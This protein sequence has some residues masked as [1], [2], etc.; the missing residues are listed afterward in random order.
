M[1]LNAYSVKALQRRGIDVAALGCVMLDVDGPPISRLLPATWLYWSEHPDRQWISGPQDS[2]HVTLLYGLLDNANTIREDVDEVLDGWETGPLTTDRVGAFPSPFEDED[3]SC[4][5]AHLSLTDN[6]RDAHARLSL[7]PHI[8][9]HAE[10]KPHATLAYV[11]R[12][13][14]QDA[15]RLI[16]QEFGC[17]K[18]YLDFTPITLNYGDLPQS[19]D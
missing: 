15:V 9:T 4:I 7:L 19:G 8:D 5:V 1:S 10:Y 16:E 14:E 12:E 11:R 2:A 18:G 17:V 3:Y 13:Y 6:L